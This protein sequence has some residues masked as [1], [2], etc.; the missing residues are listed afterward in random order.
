MRRIFVIGR[1]RPGPLPRRHRRGGGPTCRGPLG[2]AVLLGSAIAAA[3]CHGAR[4]ARPPAPSPAKVA[5]SENGTVPSDQQWIDSVALDWRGR[6]VGAERLALAGP[7]TLQ[8]RGERAGAGTS[9]AAGFGGPRGAES[10]GAGHE[11]ALSSSTS[12][13]DAALPAATTSASRSDV[14]AGAAGAAGA[15]SGSLAA[16]APLGTLLLLGLASFAIVA[17]AV[18]AWRRAGRPA[19][20]RL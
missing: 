4:A 2:F 11:G 18:R 13:A 14:A 9:R 5:V 1:C 10:S 12:Y 16:I 17:W 15:P 3:G 8:G 6:R 7:D 19:H 20:A